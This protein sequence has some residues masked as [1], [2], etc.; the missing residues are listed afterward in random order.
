M[1]PEQSTT[2]G[3]FVSS[4]RRPPLQVLFLV[5]GFL[6]LRF[7][8]VSAQS[9]VLDPEFDKL[10]EGML[11]H[12][13]PELAVDDLRNTKGLLFLDAR[14]AREFQVS[15]IPDALWVGY[16][17]FTLARLQGVDKGQ[18]I[19]VYCSVGY[20]SERVAEKLLN[21]G[22]RQVSNLYGGIFEWANQGCALT[23]EQGPTRAVHAYNQDWGKWLKTGEK[24]Y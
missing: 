15:H 21:A 14:E 13:V 22:F 3:S 24:I 2:W 1:N 20:R 18:P 17:D 11:S 4:A 16:D 7:T 12:K 5:L 9:R 10:L 19:V 6:V 23:D 8:A